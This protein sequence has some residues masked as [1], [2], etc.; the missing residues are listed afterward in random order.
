[1]WLSVPFSS[2]PDDPEPDTEVESMPGCLEALCNMGFAS[3]HIRVVANV[4]FLE[5]NPAAATLFKLVEIP[6]EEIA[7]QS[8]RM[9]VNL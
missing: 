8:V 6:L 2:R 7:A 1:M 3:S 9:L 5:A 4:E